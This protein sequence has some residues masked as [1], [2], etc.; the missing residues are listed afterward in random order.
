MGPSSVTADWFSPHAVVPTLVANPQVCTSN[1]PASLPAEILHE[2]FSYLLLPE[3]HPS[4][5]AKEDLLSFSLACCFFR[6]FFRND[7]YSAIAI[8]SPGSLFEI[9]DYLG[10][11]TWPGQPTAIK[12][13]TLRWSQEILLPDDQSI[14]ITETPSSNRV[15]PQQITPN[16]ENLL[17]SHTSSLQELTLDFPDSGIYFQNA[18]IDGRGILAHQHLKLKRLHISGGLFPSPPLATFLLCAISSLCARS[19][20]D[21]F[22]DGGCSDPGDSWMSTH[23]FCP[24]KLHVPGVLMFRQFEKLQKLRCLH[25]KNLEGF[26]EGCLSWMLSGEEM[27]SS[28]GRKGNRVLVLESNPDL[29]EAGISGALGSVEGGLEEL[30][31]TVSRR[32]AATPPAWWPWDEGGCGGATAET[33]AAFNY[34]CDVDPITGTI[35]EE[36][37]CHSNSFSSIRDCSCGTAGSSSSGACYYHRQA[38]LYASSTRSASHLRLCATARTCRHLQPLD[39]YAQTL[40]HSFFSSSPGRRRKSGNTTCHSPTPARLPTPPFEDVEDNDN[41]SFQTTSSSLFELSSD[42]GPQTLPDYPHSLRA[43]F[44]SSLSTVGEH[45]I[46]PHHVTGSR[47]GS[48]NEVRQAAKLRG[49]SGDAKIL[50]RFAGE[51]LSRVAGGFSRVW[52]GVVQ[53]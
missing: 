8:T 21:L 44:D 33:D 30:N 7:V 32:E 24:N 49:G 40:C 53:K 15:Y 5:L 52:E 17:R 18:I 1:A 43:S 38:E 45:E 16:L 22:V 46:V 34:V 27:Q 31:I 25:V 13:L 20:E 35:Y 14:I 12:Y 48:L 6:E 50:S 2:I 11:H 39:S 37:S 4:R 9:V 23:G 28:C 41:I 3:P 36:D 19:L 29:T 47:A 10:A 51:A 26:N 42:F